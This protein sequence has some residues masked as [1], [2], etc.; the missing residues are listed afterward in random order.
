[1]VAVFLHSLVDFPMQKTALA[2]LAFVLLGAL[3]ARRAR[4]PAARSSR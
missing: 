3:A 2:A 1:V 4:D